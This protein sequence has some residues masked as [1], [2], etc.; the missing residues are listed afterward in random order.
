MTPTNKAPFVMS[1]SS[2]GDGQGLLV[3]Q[4]AT[5]R[6]LPDS[7]EKIPDP[8]PFCSGAFLRGRKRVCQSQKRWGEHKTR[9]VQLRPDV[10]IFPPDH[11]FQPNLAGSAFYFLCVQSSSSLRDIGL[12]DPA[13]YSQWEADTCSLSL[14]ITE[15]AESAERKHEEVT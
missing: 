2:M 14:R 8:Q 15:N 7:P 10:M 6:V 1:P 5:Q 4:W 11:K 13:S 12:N 3:P 9:D